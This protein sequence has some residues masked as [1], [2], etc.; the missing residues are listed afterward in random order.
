MS[1]EYQRLMRIADETTEERE[2]LLERR[3]RQREQVEKQASRAAVLRE[4]RERE[5]KQTRMREHF[6]RLKREQAVSEREHQR[7]RKAQKERVQEAERRRRAR[8]NQAGRVNA[9]QWMGTASDSGTRSQTSRGGGGGGSGKRRRRNVNG[10]M[11]D[12]DPDM[13][14]SGNNNSLLINGFQQRAIPT[15]RHKVLQEHEIRVVHDPSQATACND[16]IALDQNRRDRTTIEDL[17]LERE[18]ERE[19]ALKRIKKEHGNKMI[20]LFGIKDNTTSKEVPAQHRNSIKPKSTASTSS[21]QVKAQITACPST[22]ATTNYT[23]PWAPRNGGTSNSTAS[24]ATSTSIGKSATTITTAKTAT[25]SRPS[26]AVQRPSQTTK[27]MEKQYNPS[28]PDRRSSVN[29]PS[30]STSSSLKAR[31][32][33]QEIPHRRPSSGS[34]NHHINNKYAKKQQ[35]AKDAY[36]DYDDSEEDEYEEEEDDDRYANAKGSHNDYSSVIQSIFGYNRNKYADED[37]D[38]DDMEASIHDIKREETHSTK[39]AREEDEREAE[40]ERLEMERLAARRKK[41]L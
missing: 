20:D 10:S 23:S 5:E 38:L 22:S 33:Q 19:A 7:H 37:S 40:L 21:S 26:S 31:H 24:T 17:Y 27:S 36:D 2:S 13:Q 16:L 15:A 35:Y 14:G 8:Q 34:T 4:E 12:D 6:E 3:K 29:V 11:V 32:K 18:M 9:K 28:K 41:R 1:S 39:I 30:S 25:I